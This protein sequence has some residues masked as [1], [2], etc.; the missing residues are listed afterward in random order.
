LEGQLSSVEDRI[1]QCRAG[2]IGCGFGSQTRLMYVH[3]KLYSRRYVGYQIFY[4]ASLA[5]NLNAYDL[6]VALPTHYILYN[7]SVL[8]F[9]SSP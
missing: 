3:A 8:L 1:N 6:L 7:S 9:P 4:P 5:S 2:E